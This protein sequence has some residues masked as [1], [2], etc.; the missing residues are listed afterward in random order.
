MASTHDIAKHSGIREEYINRVFESALE[1]LRNDPKG[2][3]I[4]RNF[5]AW[6]LRRRKKRTFQSP[7]RGGGKAE[8]GEKL[9]IRF[10]PTKATLKR[11][12]GSDARAPSLPRP[13][14]AT[15]D[16]FKRGR[17]GK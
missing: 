12:N 5:G 17:S 9:T 13:R 11:L 10:K 3:L 16:V 8:V 7:I 2:Q 14:A 1:V 15:G 4:V 6:R